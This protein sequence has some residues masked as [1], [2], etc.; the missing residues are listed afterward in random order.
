MFVKTKIRDSEVRSFHKIT[1]ILLREKKFVNSYWLAIRRKDAYTFNSSHCI[2]QA[3]FLIC[4]VN[5][6]DLLPV[7]FL[8]N[9]DDTRWYLGSS[10]FSPGKCRIFDLVAHIICCTKLKIKYYC[11]FFL[12]ILLFE[13]YSWIPQIISVHVYIAY[14]VSNTSNV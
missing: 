14:N 1:N 2:R 3:I 8:Q 9:A 13:Q 6:G 4:C 10:W 5:K 12:K 7:K 11:W